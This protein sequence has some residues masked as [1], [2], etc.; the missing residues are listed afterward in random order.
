MFANLSY[1]LTAFKLL[2]PIVT[3][4]PLTFRKTLFKIFF[5]LIKSLKFF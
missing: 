5:R 4:N 2:Y 3:E 1:Y